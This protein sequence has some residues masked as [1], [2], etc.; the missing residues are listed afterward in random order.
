MSRRILLLLFGLSLLLLAGCG[1]RVVVTVESYPKD[2]AGVTTACAAVLSA[3]VDD[4]GRVDFAALLDDEQALDR[5][6]AGIAVAPIP[7]ARED[8]LAY[9]LNAYHMLAIKT[10]LVQGL[11]RD[12]EA[13][14][15]RQAF[16]G[17]TTFTVDGQWLTLNGLLENLIAPSDEPRLF[18]AL[19]GM[20]AGFPRLRTEVFTG[21]RLEQQLEAAMR[22]F[23]NDPRHV[24]VENSG[25]RIVLSPLLGYYHRLLGLED[26]AAVLAFIAGYRE[27]ALPEGYQ[28]VYAPWNWTIVYQNELTDE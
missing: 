26:E 10:V 6:V 2:A 1:Q 5:A 13:Y 20:A 22:E 11:P 28:V 7:T 3:V 4:E 16:Y 14:F 27:A 15:A 12:L 23:A 17:R 24:R 25:R 8:R 19:N 21:P 9:L 18:G